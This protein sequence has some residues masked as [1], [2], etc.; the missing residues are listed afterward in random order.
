MAAQSKLAPFLIATLLITF[1][2]TG[3]NAAP[4]A[5][6]A[7]VIEHWSE[8]RRAQAIPRDLA[9][10]ERGLGY[11]R[12]PNGTLVP[13][14]HSVAAT[15]QL[16][17]AAA[18]NTPTPKGKP[19][20]GSDT[21][22]PSISNMDPAGATIGDSYTFSA[23]VTDSSGV[24]SVS[25]VIIY[26]SGLSQSFSAGSTN[27]T[28]WSINFSNFTEGSWQWQVIAK[29]NGAKGGNS[30]TSDLIPFTVSTSG[31]TGGGGNTGGNDV[32]TNAPWTEDGTAKTAVGRI[33]FEMP[34]NSKWKGP[35]NGYVCSGTV[36]DDLASG[37]SIILTA[38]HCVYDDANQAFA[39]NVLFI[40]DQTNTTAAGTDRN[41][42]N[43]PI[44]CWTPSF[45]VVDDNWTNDTFP[46]NIPWDYA[47]YVVPTIGAHST[48]V[49]ASSEELEVAAG[50]LPVSFAMPLYN[51]D[52]KSDVTYALGYS[53]SEDPH[54]MYCAEDM[55]TESDYDDWWLTSC[56]LSG[57]ASGG[58]WYQPNPSD[59]SIISV[60]SWGY[61]GSPG[62][63]G[64]HLHGNS[65]ACLLDVAEKSTPNTYEDG[66]AGIAVN[67]GLSCH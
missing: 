49:A 24:K 55:T 56:G 37:R 67:S 4:N 16:L 25:F 21:T 27:G 61:T 41:C 18:T 20:G 28:T 45:G 33:Y 1:F 31:G 15:Q 54:L 65:A 40:P 7:S 63:A 50:S 34:A 64:P 10:D 17:K 9:I 47:Y 39:R 48:G 38:A 35:W 22:P 43:D 19:S 58:S 42:N 26:P 66:L 11:L 13:Y 5:K 44:G 30:A 57:G 46:A 59:G 32:I 60:N 2:F 52:D 6:A 51:K 14:G 12:K 3:A 53:Y 62:M 8:A 29:D 23:T 36:V